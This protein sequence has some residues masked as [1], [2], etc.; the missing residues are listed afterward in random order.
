MCY[1]HS[2][3]DKHICDDGTDQRKQQRV[4]MCGGAA[5]VHSENL[6]ALL[7]SLVDGA[8]QAWQQHLA[9]PQ[10]V[11]VNRKRSQVLREDQLQ[12]THTQR[13]K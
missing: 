11:D 5:G 6:A 3:R 13:F 10:S 12:D 7:E 8:P 9:L 2:D 4:E 1:G